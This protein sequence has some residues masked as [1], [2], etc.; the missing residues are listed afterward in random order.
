MKHLGASPLRVAQVS[1]SARCF[2]LFPRASKKTSW[3]ALSKLVSLLHIMK[4]SVVPGHLRRSLSSPYFDSNHQSA[5]SW[6]DPIPTPSR[7]QCSLTT[8]AAPNIVSGHEH[9]PLI[10]PTVSPNAR[11]FCLLSAVPAHVHNSE[12]FKIDTPVFWLPQKQPRLSRVR[13]TT[14]QSSFASPHR[15]QRPTARPFP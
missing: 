15:V 1:V 12:H 10:D 7:K 3:Q 13:R 8:C 11:E 9:P 4:N 5:S 6:P 2:M 14:F